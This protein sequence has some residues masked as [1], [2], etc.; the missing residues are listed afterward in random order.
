MKEYGFVPLN[1]KENRSFAKTLFVIK[2]KSLFPIK[3]VKMPSIISIIHAAFLILFLVSLLI[4]TNK[5]QIVKK[6]NA[7]NKYSLIL[8]QAR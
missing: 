2:N 8:Q 4:K 1:K 5:R 3:M 6:N 7:G